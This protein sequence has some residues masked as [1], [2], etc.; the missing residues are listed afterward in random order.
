MTTAVM[1]SD[2]MAGL[3]TKYCKIENR[4]DTS[5]WMTA[6]SVTGTD[7]PG[8][9]KVWQPMMKI[10]C[11]E[12]NRPRPSFLLVRNAKPSLMTKTAENQQMLTDVAMLVALPREYNE[13][14][15]RVCK[16]R[17]SFLTVYMSRRLTAMSA[18]AVERAK[19]VRRYMRRSVAQTTCTCRQS[20]VSIDISV[21]ISN[22]VA[23]IELA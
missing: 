7:V 10:I 22:T 21:S 4:A 9:P 16:M 1:T 18:I 14:K 6:G 2:D 12:L 8:I 5:Q 15:G 20:E 3:S 19:I 13:S 11:I 23:V 17:M